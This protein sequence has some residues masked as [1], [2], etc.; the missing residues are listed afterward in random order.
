[1]E[2]MNGY[3]IRFLTDD[4]NQT[5]AHGI[6]PTVGE[7]QAED[8]LW[9]CVCLTQNIGGTHAE[10]FRFTG[11][12]TGHD[13]DWALDRIDGFPLRLIQLLVTCLKT[14]VAIVSELELLE[15][16]HENGQHLFIV[17]GLDRTRLFMEVND[18]IRDFYG[19]SR[20]VVVQ[21]RHEAW[22]QQL[23]CRQPVGIRR[24]DVI[25]L[26]EVRPLKFIFLIPFWSLAAK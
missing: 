21:V 4:I 12:R 20:V 19:D 15:G 8:I 10:E 7:C 11:A 13:H 6:R 3:F 22:I 23:K 18:I 25:A 16:P 5:F 9:Q 14:H 26:V 17:R 2:R 1:M 24:E